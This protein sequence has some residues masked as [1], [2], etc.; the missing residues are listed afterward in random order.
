MLI[1]VL[2]TIIIKFDNQASMATTSV[3]FSLMIQIYT[4][5]ICSLYIIILSLILLSMEDNYNGN[6][7]LVHSMQLLLNT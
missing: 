6:C 7:I 2:Y 5:I 4:V 1:N 3:L